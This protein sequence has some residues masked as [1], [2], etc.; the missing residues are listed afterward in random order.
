MPSSSASPQLTPEGHALTPAAAAI[1]WGRD[2]HT[3]K[4]GGH[5]NGQT[6]V[7][8][9]ERSVGEL[10]RKTASHPSPP[11]CK[12]P[13]VTLCCG[14]SLRMSPQPS[15]GA[16]GGLRPLHLFPLPLLTAA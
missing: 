1:L 15:A 3:G 7:P 4:A 5:L 11:T 14:Q 8:L 13:S 10:V 16:I 2:G 12:Q 9:T 6:S